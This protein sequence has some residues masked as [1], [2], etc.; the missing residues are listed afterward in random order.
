M[1]LTRAIFDNTGF[2][3]IKKR[4]K[5]LSLH[6]VDLG[7]KFSNTDS[8]PHRFQG[9][10]KTQKSDYSPFPINKPGF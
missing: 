2:E 3:T 9:P 1:V 6:Q 4:I 10:E 7:T 8:E 5:N